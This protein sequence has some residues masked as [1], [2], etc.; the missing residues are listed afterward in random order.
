MVARVILWVLYRY[1]YTYRL[2]IRLFM[3]VF[4]GG[5]LHL[6]F[7]SCGCSFPPP[8]RCVMTVVSLFRYNL[9]IHSTIVICIRR[10]VVS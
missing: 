7:V 10:C 9:V 3:V 8:I 6:D 5:N 4:V 2:I 1:R